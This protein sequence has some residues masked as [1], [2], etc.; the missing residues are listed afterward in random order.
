MTIR[1]PVAQSVASLTADL[2]VAS[3]IRHR[4]HTFMEIDR[5]LTSMVICFLALIQDRLLSVTSKSN[6]HEVLVNHLVKL[7]QKKCG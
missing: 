7:A 5:E 3:L 2:G 1:G 4:S 6:V